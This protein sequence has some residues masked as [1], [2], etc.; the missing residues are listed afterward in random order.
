M[1]I[2]SLAIKGFRNYDDTTMYFKDSTLIIGA[3]ETGKSNLLFALRIL[4]DKKLSESDLELVD[5]DYNVYTKASEIVITATIVD[6]TEECLLSIFSG[7]VREGRVVIRYSKVKNEDF[8]IF[9]GPDEDLLEERTHRFYLKRLNMEYVDSQRDLL[10]FMKRE[11]KNLL[12]NSKNMLSASLTKDDE[13][14]YRSIQ[15]KMNSMNSEIDNLNYV[16]S[17]LEQVNSEL[18]NLSINNDEQKLS[19]RTESI[20]AEELLNNLELAYSLENGSMKIGG[21]GRK[22]Q[23]FLATWIA[24]H[25]SEQS[26]ERVTFYAIEEPEAHLHPHQQRKL[27]KY[28]V[29]N[30]ANQMFIT[31]H[32]PNIAT[33]F[34]PDSIVRLFLKN[35]NVCAANG[36]C[37]H[38]IKLAFDDFGYRL[39]AISAE[40][41]FSNGVLL[42][43]GPSEVLFYKSLARGLDIDLDRNNISIIAVDGVGFKPYIKICIS[44]GIPF[45]MRT[46]NDIFSKT[47]SGKEYCYYAG[48]SRVMGIV[49]KFFCSENTELIK[50]WKKDEIKNE[51]LSTKLPNIKAAVQLQKSMKTK[52]EKLNFFLSDKNLEADLAVTA[53]RKSLYEYYKCSDDLEEI[54]KKMSVRKAENMLGYLCFLDDKDSTI[55][56]ELKDDDIAKPLLRILE[57]VERSVAIVRK[58]RTKLRAKKNN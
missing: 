37:S 19:F 21:D 26:N 46:D 34:R 24:K 53:L 36:G 32:S 58:K 20:N 45:V 2:D 15:S 7:D 51:W 57:V 1:R 41:F 42:V 5:S 55:L 39:N 23:I 35:K 14:I 30:L 3:N 10:N 25:L 48:L 40:T 28:L 6:V 56:S 9:T 29:D 33:E 31:S 52:L 54:I 11:K 44:L 18:R 16:K 49:E 27:S 50:A 47:K 13:K 12:S 38:N 43:E 17:S 8:I 22:N 4:F